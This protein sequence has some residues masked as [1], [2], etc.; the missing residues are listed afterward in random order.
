MAGTPPWQIRG[1]KVAATKRGPT[2]RDAQPRLGQLGPALARRA[3]GEKTR[4][5][6]TGSVRA[7][8]NKGVAGG[9]GVHAAAVQAMAWFI[10]VAR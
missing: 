6:F 8:R 3:A 5:P 1:L 4:L 7:L 9:S 2:E 10:R